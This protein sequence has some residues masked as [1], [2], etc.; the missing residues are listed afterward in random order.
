MWAHLGALLVTWLGGTLS[1]GLLTLAGWVFPLVVMNMYG[2][3]S[4]YVRESARESVNFQLSWLLY[5]VVLMVPLVL[6]TLVTFGLGL[7]LF[8]PVV[9]AG[10]ILE[11]V[12]NVIGA[13]KASRGELWRYPMVIRFVR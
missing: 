5:W 1:G 9:V 12:F 11:L 4:P 8:I 3:R 6:V 13:V 7:I 10:V 2:V